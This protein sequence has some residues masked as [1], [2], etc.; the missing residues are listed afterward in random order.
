MALPTG[1]RDVV[2]LAYSPSSNRLYAADLAWS[3]AGEGGIYRLDAGKVDGRSGL[4]AIK[5]ASLE[6]PTALAFAADNTLY[7][8][9]LGAPMKDGD[10]QD[11]D[12]A[13]KGMLVKITGDL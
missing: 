10:K 1:L 6:R 7:A 11:Q 12:A 13:K 5:I 2:A 3:A 8:V 4:K 9:A